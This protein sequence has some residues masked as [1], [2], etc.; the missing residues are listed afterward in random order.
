MWL[1][2]MK[3]SFVWFFDATG[4]IPI[5]IK[6][7]K[8][9]LYYSLV[10]HDSDTESLIPIAE[11]VTTSHD[12]INVTKYLNSIISIFEGN[13]KICLFPIT[14]VTDLSWVLINSVIQ[15]F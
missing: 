1:I 3:K 15:S 6:G 2:I 12:T 9:P 11:F 14:I 5:N 7:Q 10:F 8:K 13:Y 4:T